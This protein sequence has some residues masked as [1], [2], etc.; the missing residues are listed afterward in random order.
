MLLRL[1]ADTRMM[2]RTKWP[3][4]AQLLAGL[5][6]LCCR[7][8]FAS[9]IVAD[10][11]PRAPIQHYPY[12]FLPGQPFPYIAPDVEAVIE[13]RAFPPEPDLLPP[14]AYESEP[15]KLPFAEDD[16]QR[17]ILQVS[18]Q[19]LEDNAARDVDPKG[20]YAFPRWN[21]LPAPGTE[22]AWG[23]TPFKENSF[24]LSVLPAPGEDLGMTTLDWK[25]TL[26]A[27]E[28]DGQPVV[29]VT[30]R[31]GWNFLTGPTTPD[32][33]PQLYDLSLDWSVFFKFGDQWTGVVGVGPGYYTDFENDSSDAF[34]MTGRAILFYEWSS[35]LKFSGGFLYLDREDI[36]ALPVAGAIWQPSE[37]IR[38]E[39]MFPRPKV[40]K[41]VWLS[42]ERE[43]WLY[44]AGELGGGTWAIER[45]NGVGD[46][47]TYRDYRLIL[48]FESVNAD[49]SRWLL[50]AGYVFGRELEYRS[51]IGDDS[52]S[53]TAL[54]R[55][56]AA[57]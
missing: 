33:P 16:E 10:D 52:Q 27:F 31:F 18:Q 56:G 36:V 38:I 9:E 3:S 23:S 50:E 5:L 53:P 15:L 30:P 44:L 45:Q 54:I 6:A 40:A 42:S 57:F 35:Q 25:S 49:E 48:G 14:E 22:E 28:I 7:A 1:M 26:V 12:L 13:G 47:V 34:R 20:H 4:L 43:A 51:G 2:A 41:R 29:Q 37:N 8:T 32:L 17:G 46:M 24:T 19:P 55:Y 39:A 21:P 11:L